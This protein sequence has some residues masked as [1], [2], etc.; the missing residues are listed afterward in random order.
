MN[1]ILT[2]L[3][4]P[5]LFNIRAFIS[6]KVKDARREK[7]KMGQKRG[8][9]SHTRWF[10][11]TGKGKHTDSGKSGTSAHLANLTSAEDHDYCATPLQAHNDPVD[12]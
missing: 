12:P 3:P 2:E 10:R 1:V 7:A 4:K 8:D 11:G 5:S 6:E 9:N